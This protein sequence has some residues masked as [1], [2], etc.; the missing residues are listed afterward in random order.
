MSTIEDEHKLENNWVLW[1]HDYNNK[2]WS[3]ESYEKLYTIKSVEDFWR[4]FSNWND[5]LPELENN[6]YFIMK[7]G[8]MPIWEHET[9]LMGG[10]WSFRISRRNI[11]TAWTELAMK[12]F[13]NTLCKENHHM[14]NGISISPKKNY[15]IIKIWN[16]D[17]TYDDVDEFNTI[18][19][20]DLT[21]NLYKKNTDNILTDKM[22]RSI[23]K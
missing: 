13:G 16:N 15:S 6:M 19:F 9:N 18:P 14:I 21:N 2:D 5:A 22:K 11:F 3:L 12:M 10:C 17:Q 20:I 7:E 4:L 23:M 1:F 8:V